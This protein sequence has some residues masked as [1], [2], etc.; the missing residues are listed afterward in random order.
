[1]TS[2]SAKCPIFSIRSFSESVKSSD[3][4][5]SYTRYAVLCA[6]IICL[7]SVMANIICFNF[8]VLCMPATHE[9]LSVNETHYH[10]YSKNERTWLFSAV[11]VGALIS[12]VPTS[13]AIAT[14]GARYR[15]EPGC[16]VGDS[17]A[18]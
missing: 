10:G 3:D 18:V 5:R 12:V 16:V 4:D 11:A 15:I 8:T 13:H 14:I 7:S 2:L 17:H 1:M 9:E 6:T